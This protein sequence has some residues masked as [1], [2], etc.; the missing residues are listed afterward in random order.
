MAIVFQD[1]VLQRG[2]PRPLRFYYFIPAIVVFIII[3]GFFFGLPPGPLC[4][5]GMVLFMEGGCDMGESNIFFFSKLGALLAVNFAFVVASRQP[6]ARAYAFLPHLLLLSWLGWYHRSGGRCDTYYSHPNGSIGQMA[7]EIAA[8]AVLGI[9]LLPFARGRSLP[10]V[11]TA[12]AAWNA[13]HV[14]AFYLCLQ[15][16]DH[17]TWDHTW[18]V[19]ATMLVVGGFGFTGVKVL[20]GRGGRGH[21]RKRLPGAAQ[22]NGPLV[23]EAGS[24]ADRLLL[25]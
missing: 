20:I 4:D 6:T 15:V 14:G 18:L 16:A 9:A 23:L 11:F 8:F 7:L 3:T 12:L 25:A 10:D 1:I 21:V 13:V 2:L 19:C 24:G 22:G 17:W 5:E